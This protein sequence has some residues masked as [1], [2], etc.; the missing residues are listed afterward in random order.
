MAATKLNERRWRDSWV[1]IASCTT[2][3][4]RGRRTAKLF[5]RGLAVEAQDFG[6]QAVARRSLTLCPLLLWLAKCISF[7]QTLSLLP[8]A[9]FS[10][11]FYPQTKF[12]HTPVTVRMDYQEARPEHLGQQ[13][14]GL[15]KCTRWL[16]VAI[17]ILVIR[18]TLLRMMIRRMVANRR[19][20]SSWCNRCVCVAPSKVAFT[21]ALLAIS[22]SVAGC[23]S[24]HSWHFEAVDPGRRGRD[25][26]LNW[27]S[28]KASLLYRSFPFPRN[29]HTGLAMLKFHK[30]T[31]P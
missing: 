8:R 14:A 10:F 5:P 28:G 25:R 18:S 17:M 12:I 9:L 31:L 16:L 22:I 24:H 26:E 6:T 21:I 7:A 15:N 19:S 29:K 20:N 1:R 27:R 13:P 2:F 11:L 3:T 4:R 23:Q 30:L